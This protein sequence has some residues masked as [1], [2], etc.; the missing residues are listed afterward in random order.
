MFNNVGAKIKTLATVL[1][2]LNVVFTIIGVLLLCSAIDSL[3]ALDFAATFL[4]LVFLAALG[5]CISWIFSLFVYGFG[6]L[7]QN[8]ET[9]MYNSANEYYDEA[10][11]EDTEEASK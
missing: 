7:V 10:N 3:R 8:A 4:L 5:C 9:S 6:I 2:I 11:Y 1:F